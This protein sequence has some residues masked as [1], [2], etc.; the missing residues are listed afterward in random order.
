MDTV[1]KQELISSYAG[2]KQLVFA[3]EMPLLWFI[4]M[5]CELGNGYLLQLPYHA[6]TKH[7]PTQHSLYLVHS[8]SVPLVCLPQSSGQ[9]TAQLFSRWSVMIRE[10]FGSRHSAQIF[11]S[12]ELLEHHVKMSTEGFGTAN[13]FLKQIVTNSASEFVFIHIQTGSLLFFSS[14]TAA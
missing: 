10:L 4:D 6:M 1:A 11:Y 5:L 2:G 7:T 8:P 9:C 12:C 13:C 3:N 14:S